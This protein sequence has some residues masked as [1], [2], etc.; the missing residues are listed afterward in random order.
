MIIIFR[1]LSIAI[2]IWMMIF[3]L[4]G[5]FRELYKILKAGYE[6]WKNRKRILREA[7]KLVKEG[8]L[9]WDDRKKG[10]MRM[11]RK[12]MKSYEGGLKNK[13]SKI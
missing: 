1:N 7:D 6:D 8:L 3:F 4:H 9:E 2:L 5:F 12:G 10:S 13:K 11:T